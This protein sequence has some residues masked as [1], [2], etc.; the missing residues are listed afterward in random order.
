MVN[1]LA[2][3][4]LSVSRVESSSQTWG[5]LVV[6]VAASG[7]YADLKNW[8]GVLLA[9]F[10][11]LVVQSLR[12]QLLAGGGSGSGATEAQVTWVLYVRD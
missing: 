10:H 5:Q 6:E 12:L 7:A 3:R 1:G 11:S 4:T 8:Q 2:L 9:R